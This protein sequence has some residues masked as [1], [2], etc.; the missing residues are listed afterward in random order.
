M[1]TTA[2]Q[3]WGED[4][5]EAQRWKAKLA[6]AKDE[7]N[8]NKTLPAKIATAQQQR[9]HAER[10]LDHERAQLKKK[11]QAATA[12]RL[13]LSNAEAELQ[14]AQ[15]RVDQQQDI[16][17]K[18]DDTLR[19][20]SQ[21]SVGEAADDSVAPAPGAT[22]TAQQVQWTKEQLQGILGQLS[23][24]TSKRIVQQ[25][26]AQGMR[27]AGGPAPEAGSP[28]DAQVHTAPTQID[29]TQT[30]TV[31]D[32]QDAGQTP[33]PADTCGDVHMLPSVRH[34]PEPDPATPRA[35]ATDEGTPGGRHT[36]LTDGTPGSGPTHR[37]RKK[38]KFHG[39]DAGTN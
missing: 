11:E 14:S 8:A 13:Q 38:A 26:F 10:R 21:Q 34:H 37:H 3:Q 17:R 33:R 24:P 22:D 7:Y 25:V 19:E 12:A 23:D 27:P 20:L 36:R 29:N 5:P 6:E 9:T 16:L 4:H 15:Q 28:A 32:S 31:L 1:L 2:I 35:D 39:L 18:A 30:I